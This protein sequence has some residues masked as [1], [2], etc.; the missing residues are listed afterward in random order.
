MGKNDFVCGMCHRPIK[1]GHRTINGIESLFFAH[2]N[3][4]EYCPW[5]PYTAS[6]KDNDILIDDS[7]IDIDTIEQG[8]ATKPHSRVLKEMIFSLQME[9]QHLKA[10]KI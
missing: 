2:A 8:E 1:I 6:S 7:D 3:H 10:V 5:I 4:N 9:K